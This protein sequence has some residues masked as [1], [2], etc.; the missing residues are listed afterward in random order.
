[1]LH[2]KKIPYLK[3][4]PAGFDDRLGRGGWS[5]ASPLQKVGGGT[6][7]LPHLDRARSAWKFFGFFPLYLA[8]TKISYWPP[9]RGGGWSGPP[10][11]KVGGPGDGMCDDPVIKP[12]RPVSVCHIHDIILLYSFSLNVNK[13]NSGISYTIYWCPKAQLDLGILFLVF[14]QGG[15]YAKEKPNLITFFYLKR[16][17]LIKFFKN[18]IGSLC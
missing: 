2:L 12:C 18:R 9:A 1:M 5:E 4:R 17:F 6:G 11:Q 14:G 7:G 13:H 15:G 3:D 8:W 16:S 10:L